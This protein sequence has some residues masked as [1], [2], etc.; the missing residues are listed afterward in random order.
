MSEMI[1]RRRRTGRTAVVAVLALGASIAAAPAAA[2][3]RTPGGV[4]A[5][6]VWNSHAQTAIYEV[7]RQPPHETARSFAMVQGAVYDAVNAI[8]GVPYEPYLVAPH[9]RRGDSVDAAVAG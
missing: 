8:A 7:A 3:A 4:N 6:V 1:S 5:V 9:A 2:Q